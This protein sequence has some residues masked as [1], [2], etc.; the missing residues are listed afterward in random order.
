L[1]GAFYRTHLFERC[2]N[3]HQCRR[4]QMCTN[5]NPH[6]AMCVA[7]EAV[8]PGRRHM[9]SVLQIEALVR[10]EEIMGRPMFDIN[11]EAKNVC[12]ELM[13]SWQSENATLVQE[14]TGGH[15]T[16]DQ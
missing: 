1:R 5:Y 8:K 15:E 13:D 6:D 16:P 7:C 12:T 14:Y 9:C 3:F 10:M 11:A 2:P 4:C